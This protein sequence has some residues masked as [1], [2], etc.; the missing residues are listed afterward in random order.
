MIRD[1]FL[2]FTPSF[3][4]PLVI[5]FIEMVHSRGYSTQMDFGFWDFYVYEDSEEPAMAVKTVKNRITRPQLSRLVADD[6]PLKVILIEGNHPAWAEL[7]K[8]KLFLATTG[9]GVF[10]RNVGW[11]SLP[12]EPAVDKVEDL[13]LKLAPRWSQRDDGVW[14]KTCTKCG[15]QKTQIDF[16]ASAYKTARDP[17]RNMCKS[18]FT[19]QTADAN[20]RALEAA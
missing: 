1:D 16:Y 13:Q 19:K 18:C 7:E 6:V 17:Y 4:A 8:Q 5:S 12:G 15:K 10:V 3:E 11:R 9:T 2:A 14:V 20:R